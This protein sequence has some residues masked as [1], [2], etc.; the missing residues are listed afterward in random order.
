LPCS[1]GDAFRASHYFNALKIALKMHLFEKRFRIHF[2]DVIG[3]ADP[4]MRELE[5]GD[6]SEG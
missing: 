5:K 1:G 4:N 2:E 3:W 6:R